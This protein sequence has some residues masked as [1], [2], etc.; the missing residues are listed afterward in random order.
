[1]IIIINLAL[2]T[3][4]LLELGVFTGRQHRVDDAN[5]VNLAGCVPPPPPPPPLVTESYGTWGKDAVEAF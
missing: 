2:N 1:M 4:N 3:L 5:A